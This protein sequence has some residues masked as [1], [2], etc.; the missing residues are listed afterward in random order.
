[1]DKDRQVERRQAGMQTNT[2]RQIDIR[3]VSDRLTCHSYIPV[4]DDATPHADRVCVNEIGI[5]SCL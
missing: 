5:L 1:M 4:V 2:D 3:H